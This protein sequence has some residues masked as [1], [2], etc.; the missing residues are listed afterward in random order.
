MYLNQVE[1]GVI[2]HISSPSSGEMEIPRPLWDTAQP[3]Q[4]ELDKSDQLKSSESN[5]V[6]LLGNI[7]GFCI[8]AF[9]THTH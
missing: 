2:V 3:A 4:V 9:F 8:T 5:Y 7:G 1:V 6:M